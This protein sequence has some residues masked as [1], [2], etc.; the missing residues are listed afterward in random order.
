MHLGIS[1]GQA[2][3]ESFPTVIRNVLSGVAASLK[4][5]V[6][7]PL[8]ARKDGRRDHHRAGLINIYDVRV[9]KV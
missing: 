1:Q 9:T 3:A 5:V 2:R 4:N 8:Q 7:A 6:V